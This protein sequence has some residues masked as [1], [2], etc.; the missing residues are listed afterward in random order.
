M[1]GKSR[2][3][4]AVAGVTTVKNPINAA[5]AVMTQ[6][7]HVLMVSTGADTFAKNRDSQSLIRL[8]SKLIFAGS[9]YR[10]QLKRKVLWITTERAQLCLLIR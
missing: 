1:D 9:N 3:A 10:M 6:S 4:G 2:K 5:Y 7:P 8:I